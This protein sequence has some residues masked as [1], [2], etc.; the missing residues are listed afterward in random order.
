MTVTMK[1][2][3]PG[4]RPTAPDGCHWF[5]DC[6]GCGW[7]TCVVNA[8]VKYSTDKGKEL[9]GMAFARMLQAGTSV[10]SMAAFFGVAEDDV[11][12]E[13]EPYRQTCF[14]NRSNYS[15]VDRVLLKNEAVRRRLEGMPELMVACSM[16]VSPRQVRRWCH[17][18]EGINRGDGNR[19]RKALSSMTPVHGMTV[20][21]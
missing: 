9:R 11:L 19:W 12:A 8:P 18:V 17:G 7:K 5:D 15:P 3:G 2:L 10:V 6:E 21:D 14:E 1:A 20:K 13:A 4:D 16:R